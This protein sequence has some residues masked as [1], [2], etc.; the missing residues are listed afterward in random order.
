MSIDIDEAK[1]ERNEV[2]LWLAWTA[3]TTLGMLIG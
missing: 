1:V 2:G 3:A